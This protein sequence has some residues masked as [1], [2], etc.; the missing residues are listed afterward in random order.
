MLEDLAPSLPASAAASERPAPSG[1][2]VSPDSVA[3]ADGPVADP[4]GS[5]LWV[6]RS[7]EAERVLSFISAAAGRL[8]VLY[9]KRGI[10]KTALICRWVL[11]RLGDG[12]GSYTDVQTA[13]LGKGDRGG[14]VDRL[15]A[16]MRS[17]S[18]VFVDSAEE[19]LDADAAERNL[20]LHRAMALAK[21]L[22]LVVNEERLRDVFALRSQF[23]EILDH[24][25]EIAGVDLRCGLATLLPSGAASGSAEGNLAAALLG[26]TAEENLGVLAGK[27]GGVSPGLLRI[28]DSRLRRSPA[29]AADPAGAATA[30]AEHSGDRG[31]PGLDSLLWD[32]ARDRLEAIPAGALLPK[33]RFEL[34][35][36]IVEEVAAFGKAAAPVQLQDIALRVGAGI[37]ECRRV[38]AHLQGADGLIRELEEGRYALVPPEL[39]KV[40]AAESSRRRANAWESEHLI[41]Q[42]VAAWRGENALLPRRAF[43]EVQKHRRSL[44]LQPEE[45]NLLVRSALLH[46]DE[47]EL[48]AARYWLQRLANPQAATDILLSSL[49]HPTEKVRS[50]ASTLLGELPEPAVRDQLHSLALRDPDPGVR[51]CAASSLARMKT[52]ELRGLLAAEVRAE[53][54]PYRR[55]ALATLRIFDDAATVEIIRS[56]LDGGV[57][58][59]GLRRTAIQV[60][61]ELGV[62]EAADFLLELALSAPDADCRQ[63]AATGL[64]AI[65]SEALQ[66]HILGALRGSPRPALPSARARAGAALGGMLLALGVALINTFVH[67]FVLLLRKRNRYAVALLAVEGLGAALWMWGVVLQPYLPDAV[68]AASLGTVGAIIM[69]LTWTLSQLGGL[70]VLL[71]DRREGRTTGLPASGVLAALLCLGCLI[72]P[73]FWF[74]HGLVHASVHRLRRGAML[75]GIEAAG[76]LLAASMTSLDTLNLADASNR[77]DYLFALTARSYRWLGI[78]LFVGS[79]VYDVAGVLMREIVF[80]DVLESS[81]RR[82]GLYRLL[83]KNPAAA[84]RVMAGLA[85]ADRTEAR[86]ARW[87]MSRFGSDI[88][89]GLLLAELKGPR[90]AAPAPI[91]RSLARSKTEA[92]IHALTAAWDTSDRGTRETMVA[93]LTMEPS[94]ASIAALAERRRELTW[95]QRCRYGLAAWRFRFGVWPRLA[96]TCLVLGVPLVVVLGS[97]GYLTLTEPFSPQLRIVESHPKSASEDIRRLRTAEFLASVYPHDSYAR[98]AALFRNQQESAESRAG[99]AK[100]LSFII[101]RGDDPEREAARTALIRASQRAENPALRKAA[102]TNIASTLRD[103]SDAATSKALLPVLSVILGDERDDMALRRLALAGLAAMGSPEASA[104]LSR[105]AAS[106]PPPPPGPAGISDMDL[107]SEEDIRL[108]TVTALWRM[109]IPDA[110]A[111]LGNLAAAPLAAALREAARQASTDPLWRIRD[112]LAHGKADHAAKLAEQFVADSTAGLAPAAEVF[113]LLGKAHY[114]MASG[115]PGGQGHEDWRSA[116]DSLLKAERA[117]SQD[118]DVPRLL[119]LVEELEQSSYRKEL[120]RPMRSSR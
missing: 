81:Q 21:R 83:L 65:R 7:A 28:V 31:Q 14:Q 118:R 79:F 6:D 43:R 40:V 36:A 104:V 111:E 49:F 71:D 60:L 25:L 75:L 94:E 16:A 88:E 1:A 12:G 116:R 106:G 19:L 15:S 64:A 5:L 115:A 119:A 30:A 39:A 44:R 54:S 51:Q 99:L 68:E 24:T 46:D 57:L 56:L 23:P 8:I 26:R 53:R 27:S 107:R 101:L 4:G 13:L 34:G 76:I 105:F 29:P 22:V 84:R 9:G 48:P 47:P 89:P 110:I 97:E 93:I 41:D 38:L 67:G 11:P 37:D 70:R 42:A 80:G 109:G 120:L 66:A 10:G 98:L 78:L 61:S 33:T 77:W 52:E 95:R 2:P 96:L 69:L 3:A 32:Y 92:T 91:I 117:G 114:Q 100:S 72:N 112:D 17:G 102:L 45:I 85:S 63:A 55:E 62:A 18:V 103:R 90:P 87:I 35:L 50:R 73:V 58:A 108:E 20:F 59:P 113:A 86:W 74:I 82:R